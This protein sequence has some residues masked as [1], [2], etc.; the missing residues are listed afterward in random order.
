MSAIFS[1]EQD[2]FLLEQG[3]KFTVKELAAHFDRTEKQVRQALYRLEV[4]AKPFDGWDDEKIAA[5]REHSKTMSAREVATHMGVAV[6]II[7]RR[8][9][10]LG[11]KFACRA[12]GGRAAQNGAVKARRWTPAEDV[13]L[14]SLSERYSVASIAKQL[15]RTVYAVR[16]R[17]NTKGFGT[18]QGLYSAQE[19]GEL[20]G[21]SPN[22]AW[23]WRK[24]LN[25]K[26][27]SGK[28][29]NFT[30]H[31]VCTMALSY[32]NGS[33]KS[34]TVLSNA[35]LLALIESLRTEDDAATRNMVDAALANRE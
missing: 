3:S 30:D 12:I 4:K 22:T 15:D 7:R 21:I 26:F 16:E 32:L 24:K 8:A 27:A 25:L 20:L 2:A 23:V 5:L 11:I 35:N 14:L 18:T 19:A 31:H 6:S 10:E 1:L 28:K 29:K 9:C 33:L 17:L 13:Q 34:S